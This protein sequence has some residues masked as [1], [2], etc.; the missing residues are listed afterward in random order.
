MHL[1]MEDR[2]SLA[3]DV[4]IRQATGHG[5]APCGE[6][7]V[8]IG[9]AYISRSSTAYSARVTARDVTNG[10]PSVRRHSNGEDVLRKETGGNCP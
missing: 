4:V 6:R 1:P 2:S 7:Q 9:C 8:S 3:T 10:R 5:R